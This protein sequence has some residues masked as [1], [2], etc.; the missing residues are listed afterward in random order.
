MFKKR[1]RAPVF[2]L[3][4]DDDKKWIIF[5]Q[6]EFSLPNDRL[7]SVPATLQN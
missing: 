1:Q 4:D 7:L 6:V 2:A 5:K 3:Y